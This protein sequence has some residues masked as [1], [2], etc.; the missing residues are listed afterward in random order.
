MSNVFVHMGI[1][2]DGYVAGPNRGSK[3]PL[4]DGGLTIQEWMFKQRAFRHEL[5]L[6]EDGETGPD[7]RVVEGIMNRIGANIMGKRMF[8]EGEANWP[9]E[10]PFHTPV[11]VLTKEVRSPWERKGGTT[12]YFV[13][14]GIERAL[15]RAR[16]AAGAKD[17]RISGGRDVVLRYL[18]AGLVDELSLALTLVFLGE[19]LRLFDG[20]DKRAV[21]LEI[22]EATPSPAVTH[23]RYVVKK[24]RME[25]R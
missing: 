6:G 20:I 22:G 13:N 21:E 15:G 1:S 7:N 12:F 17:V 3:N 2:L 9:E 11:F 19:G 10:A 5:K 18:N 23:L 16:K 8:E 14:D 4:G 24:R 25:S